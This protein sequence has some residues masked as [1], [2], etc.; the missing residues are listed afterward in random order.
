MKEIK[1]YNLLV[2]VT[3]T[4]RI[5]IKEVSTS[6]GLTQSELVLFLITRKA[7]ALKR[8]QK[9]CAKKAYQKRASAIADDLRLLT[10]HKT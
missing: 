2:R 10:A 5:M 7:K 8:R 3:K 4:E 1:S 6:M 9:K